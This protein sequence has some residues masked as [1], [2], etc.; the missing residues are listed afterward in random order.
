MLVRGRSMQPTLGD[1][2]LIISHTIKDSSGLGYGDVITFH[3]IPDGQVTYV[4]R[5][6]GLP[7]DILEARSN[8]LFVNGVSDGISQ[9]GTGTWGPITVPPNT[10][11]LLGD[12]RV[13]SCDSRTLGCISFSQICAKVIGK[14]VLLS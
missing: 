13:A 14:S 7:G 5:V 3:P 10:V 1:G 11:F 4:K 9:T 12:N 6:V 2:T 8:F